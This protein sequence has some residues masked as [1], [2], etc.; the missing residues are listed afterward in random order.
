MAA[1]WAGG[2]ETAMK[3][4]QVFQYGDGIN[5]GNVNIFPLRSISVNASNVSS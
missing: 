3:L 2:R 4:L 5:F 1:E